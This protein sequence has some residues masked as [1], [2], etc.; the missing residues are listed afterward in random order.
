MMA[1]SRIVVIF[2]SVVM[3]WSNMVVI[4]S[5]VVIRVLMV[6]RIM[7]NVQVFHHDTFEVLCHSNIIH[8]LLQVF[9]HG[10]ITILLS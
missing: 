5:I 1:R 2:C 8:G 7:L 10:Q 9:G 4:L 6:M 3:A